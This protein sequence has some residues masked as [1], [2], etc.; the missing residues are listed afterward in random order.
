MKSLKRKR[1]TKL[2][3]KKVKSNSHGKL[4]TTEN[5]DANSPVSDQPGGAIDIAERIQ[6]RMRDVLAQYSIEMESGPFLE[7]PI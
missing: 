7:T 2:V 4:A 3:S 5:T 6:T 1:G